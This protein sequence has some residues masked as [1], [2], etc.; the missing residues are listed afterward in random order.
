MGELIRVPKP[1]PGADAL[2]ELIG[3]E[4]RVKFANDPA[5]REFDVVSDTYIGQ[6]KPGITY[7]SD[8][9]DQAK[10]TFQM[11]IITGRTPYF[12]FESTPGPDILEALQRYSVRYDLAPVV[13]QPGF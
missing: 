9:R 3:C 11:S 4:P 8:F 1:D 7:G 12:Y 10:A 6:V 5:G 2:S 13:S